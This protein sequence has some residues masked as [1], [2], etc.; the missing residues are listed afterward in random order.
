MA[1]TTVTDESSNSVS[2][3]I[4]KYRD[5]RR[6]AATDFDNNIKQVRKAVTK[7]NQTY[8]KNETHC[9]DAFR[10]IM[11]LIYQPDASN[12]SNLP[13]SELNKSGLRHKTEDLKEICLR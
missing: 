8:Q 7:L 6:K 2:S 13:L 11:D 10:K 5:C 9:N 1:N 12:S 3:A 4:L